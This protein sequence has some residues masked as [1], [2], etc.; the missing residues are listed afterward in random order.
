MTV[1]IAGASGAVGIPDCQRADQA[2]PRGGSNDS[3]GAWHT[4]AANTGR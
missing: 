3:F 4:T 2:R 1:F